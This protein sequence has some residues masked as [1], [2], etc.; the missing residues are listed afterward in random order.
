MEL[1]VAVLLLIVFAGVFSAFRFYS[2]RKKKTRFI[3]GYC[4]L[5]A[6]LFALIIYVVLT[7]L[8]LEGISS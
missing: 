2:S 6:I 7:F 4:I 3:V 8:L 1:W 5:G